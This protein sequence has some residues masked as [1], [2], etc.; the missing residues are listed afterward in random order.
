[1]LRKMKFLK[2]EG[3]MSVAVKK[4]RAIASQEKFQ[5]GWPVVGEYRLG[6]KIPFFGRVLNYTLETGN[7]PE[8]YFSIIRSF[9]WVVVFGVTT[10]DQVVTL[11]QWKPGSRNNALWELPLGGIGKVEAGASMDLITEKSKEAYL[12][13]TGFADGSWFYLG[14]ALVET[15]KYRGVS[16]ED[17][18]FPAHMFLATG[19]SW[20]QN[21][22]EPNPNEIMETLLVPL[23]EWP[24]V[25]ASGLF[26]EISA[27]LCAYRALVEI[28]KL[29]WAQ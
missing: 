13:E 11:V 20:A 23:D 7:G 14:K 6:V 17:R 5:R 24:E 12:R 28:G 16:P 26:L 18:G 10:E 9:G 21:A 27:V 19:L 2:K 3:K 22:R 25:L 8:E 15:G 29:R 1:M 4:F